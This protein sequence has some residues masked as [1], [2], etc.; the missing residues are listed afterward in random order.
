MRQLI[1]EGVARLRICKIAA[2]FAPPHNGIHHAADQLPYRSFALL[3]PGLS[4]EIFAGDDICRRLRPALWHFN[5]F[6]AE[7]RHALLVSDQSRALLPFDHVEGRLLPVG[8]VPLE[9]QTFSRAGRGLLCSRICGRGIPAQSM[10][11]RGHPSLRA[12]GSPLARGGTLLFYSSASHRG[13]AL[14]FR[15]WAEA[16]ATLIRS[17]REN[18]QRKKSRPLYGRT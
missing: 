8:K 6:L 16:N 1:A 18:G 11:H 4:V 13:A 5:V 17:D 2:L 7:D 10:F 15:G 14:R 9:T 3:R 12:L